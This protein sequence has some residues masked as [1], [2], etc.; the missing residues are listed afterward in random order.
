[1]KNYHFLVEIGLNQQSKETIEPFLNTI[2]IP[3][4][5]SQHKELRRAL[6]SIITT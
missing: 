4:N 5:K 3:S 2:Q 1:M 6:N